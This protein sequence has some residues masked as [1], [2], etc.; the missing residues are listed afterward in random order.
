MKVA[1]TMQR[2][3]I[4][5]DNAENIPD[6]AIPR[7][8]HWGGY[9]V[10]ADA[11]ELWVGNSARVHDRARWTRELTPKAEGFDPGPWNACR[12]QP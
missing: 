6:D 4:D 1:D 11:V 12:L 3:G 7:P 8:P 5:F 2:F 10:W 9:R